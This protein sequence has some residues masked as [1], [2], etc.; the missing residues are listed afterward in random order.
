MRR[1]FA[2]IGFSYFLGMIFASVFLSFPQIGLGFTAVI[3]IISIISLAFG[4]NKNIGI[5]ALIMGAG[6]LVFTVAHTKGSEAAE[7]TDREIYPLNATVVGGRSFDEDKF[8][9]TISAD[10]YGNKQNILLYTDDILGIGDKI[11]VNA[12]LKKIVDTASFCARRYYNADGI[13]INAYPTEEIKIIEKGN[14]PLDCIDDIREYVATRISI[15]TDGDTGALIRAIFLGDKTALSFKQSFDIRSCGAVHFTA[16]S[17]LHLTIICSM[18]SVILRL[19]TAGRLPLTRSISILVLILLMTFFYGFNPS[20]MRS[21]VMLAMCN[22][23][24][25]FFR[26]TD[27]LNSLGFA[28]LL[29]CIINP[30]ACL[31]SGM[32]FTAAATAGCGVAGP[33]LASR[34]K[35]RFTSL[36]DKAT[37]TVC[38]SVCACALTAPVSAMLFGSFSVWSVPVSFLVMPFMGTALLFTLIFALTGGIF[39]ILILLSSVACY[40][41]G[42]IF[43]LFSG[44]FLGGISFDT[45]FGVTVTLLSGIIAY[46]ISLLLK[47]RKYDIGLFYTI[48]ALCSCVVSFGKI[49][50]NAVYLYSD[51]DMGA[52]LCV[53][54]GHKAGVITGNKGSAEAL[55]NMLREYHVNSLDVLVIY[56]RGENSGRYINTLFSPFTD[57]ILCG[58]DCKW[59]ITDTPT[60]TE[61]SSPL[62][63][64][65]EKGFYCNIEGNN[66]F[67]ANEEKY[68]Q[69]ADANITYST[70]AYSNGIILST[71]RYANEDCINLYYNDC[72]IKFD[73]DGYMIPSFNFTNR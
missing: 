32:L 45:R 40:I 71:S 28:V 38:C 69:F 42:G 52:M 68:D 73:K 62:F 8:S 55:Y 35:A 24:E 25:I 19:M 46:F 64:G 22:I 30:T 70:K 60:V 61:Y 44:F 54:E 14:S 72:I 43:S 5:I 53:S 26:K 63:N 34:L 29:I 33:K 36:P 15:K 39:D 57:V 58:D 6:C 23:G 56:A 16:V 59:L 21:A 48:F 4:K 66:I 18:L 10:V 1:K 13:Y 41:S 20:V 17:G 65:D 51:G 3:L 50:D 9:Y 27:C 11:E 67:I 7:I 31:D 2:V 47:V 37:E 49:K 12:R